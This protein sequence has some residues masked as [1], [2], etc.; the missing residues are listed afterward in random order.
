MT[1]K[2]YVMK[3][4]YFLEEYWNLAPGLIKMME[5]NEISDEWIVWL[6]DIISKAVNE[7]TDEKLKEKLSVSMKYIQKIQKIEEKQS[8]E[9][10]DELDELERLIQSA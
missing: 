6:Y 10:M 9:E 8:Q 5:N 7:V 2:E 4:L 1:K 3:A